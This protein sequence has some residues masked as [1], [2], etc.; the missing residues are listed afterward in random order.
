MPNSLAR[1]DLFPQPPAFNWTITREQSVERT[2]DQQ[3]NAVEGMLGE[4]AEMMRDT[5]MMS[6]KALGIDTWFTSLLSS[7]GECTI[8]PATPEHMDEDEDMGM[9]EMSA[10]LQV[11]Q[12]AIDSIYLPSCT[13]SKDV[14]D[15]LYDASLSGD[16]EQGSTSTPDRAGPN[17]KSTS[18]LY[19]EPY[20]VT[21]VLESVVERAEDVSLH[22][23]EEDTPARKQALEVPRSILKKRHTDDGDTARAKSPRE[24][25]TSMSAGKRVRFSI[26]ARPYRERRNSNPFL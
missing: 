18:P 19:V 4:A 23:E 25:S 11:V 13:L 12:D 15:S 16:E 7:M 3:K 2:I 6:L 1:T 14:R 22:I 24:R 26:T 17:S 10:E 20:N 9:A 8:T 5:K 21:R